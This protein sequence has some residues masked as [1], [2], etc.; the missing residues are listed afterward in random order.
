[1]LKKY[2]IDLEQ[3]SS[4]QYLTG[5]LLVIV[6]L[7][8]LFFPLTD[9]DAAHHANIALHMYET[10]DYAS[11]VD[12]GKPYL[13]KPHFLFWVS[14]ISFKIF[15]VNHF[16]HRFPAF[17]F[18]L[19][20]VYSTYKLTKHLTNRTTAKIAAIMLGTSQAFV[21]SITDARMET[22]LTA[23][24][25]FSLWQMIVYVD[26]K[27]LSNLF[28]AAL[29]MAV[30]FSTKGWLGPLVIFISIFFKILLDKKWNIFLSIKTWLFL[31]I[32]FL[33][34][35]PVLYAYYLQYDLHP[36]IV[37]RGQNHI[38]GVKFILWQ[39]LFERYKGFDEGGRYSSYFFL[40]HTFLWAFFP[41]SIAAYVGIFFW[42]RRIV[43]RRKWTHPLSFA[44]LSFTFMLVT[45]S[46]SKFKMPHYII[47]LLPL[48]AIFTAPYL[49]LALSYVWGRRLYLPIQTF[50][51]GFIFVA[52]ILLN[53]YFFKPVNI[54]IWVFGSM[55]LLLLAFLVIRR[56]N[57]KAMKILSV[58]I[59]LSICFNFFLNYNF[60]PNLLKYQAGNE[61]VELMKKSGM[62]IPDK[63]IM[64]IELNAHSFDFCR[65]HN[66][67]VVENFLVDYPVIKDKYF[68]L[69]SG[70]K[71]ELEAKGFQI[72]PVVEHVDYN[73]NTVKLKFL[74]PAKRISQCDTLMLARIYRQ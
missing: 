32:F 56:F 38:S 59:F 73:V 4:I 19:L 20:S 7:G 72:N 66:H 12:R 51:G 27:R 50:F 58:S 17:I 41:W 44:A 26:K 33:F 69:N 25:I 48:A 8:S 42:L 9:K 47:M 31:P 71:R 70:N 37:V 23:A 21:L 39:Q 1:M 65:K 18:A 5:F 45:I 74:N 24:V 62:R 52:I 55:M 36:E 2:S 29:G 14:L 46:F 13:D 28:L 30:A 49:R 35:S 53:Y 15:G 54:F 43:Y 34:I 68:L 16:A 40:Y 63:E 10:G 64:L 11:L 22:P 60:F 6:Y 61:L 3:H 57:S 67:D